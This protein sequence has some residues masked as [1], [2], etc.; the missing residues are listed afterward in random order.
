MIFINHKNPKTALSKITLKTILMMLV[1]FISIT[2]TSAN[3]KKLNISLTP[4]TMCY[5][6]DGNKVMQSFFIDK[7]EGVAWLSFDEKDHKKQ[8]ISKIK[9]GKLLESQIYVQSNS[10]GHLDGFY[11]KNSHIITTDK[12][13]TPSIVKLYQGKV[14]QRTSYPFP[15][16]GNQ[17]I[18]FNELSPSTFA[19]W[20]SNDKKTKSIFI[21]E[22][23]HK[24]FKINKLIKTSI[25]YPQNEILQGISIDK[26]FIIVVTGDK[27]MTPKLYKWNYAGRLIYNSDIIVNKTWSEYGYFEPEGIVFS[28]P[29]KA[30]IGFARKELM[31]GKIIISNCLYEINL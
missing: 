10:I 16:F 5:T 23:D 6:N 12:F 30:T 9:N 14:I 11:V 2:S 22:F 3:N 27:N 4:Q 17:I 26:D 29:S 1:T 24:K 28:S 8:I 21:G 31:D 20:A 18:A 25:S 7:S 15:I 19:L 13:K